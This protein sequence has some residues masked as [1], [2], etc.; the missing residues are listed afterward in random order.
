VDGSDARDSRNRITSLT[1]PLKGCAPASI[2]P[3]HAKHLKPLEPGGSR[4]S[5][6]LS[7]LTR[8]TRSLQTSRSGER[9]T[10][11]PTLFSADILALLLQ[12]K[13]VHRMLWRSTGRLMRF[14]CKSTRGGD[15]GTHGTYSNAQYCDTRLKIQTARG[16]RQGHVLQAVIARQADREWK[17]SSFLY[18]NG[19][20][21]PMKKGTI[22]SPWRYDKFRLYAPQ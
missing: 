5:G 11:I 13:F 20:P 16:R 8:R 15:L 2:V 22:V 19:A 9:K 17:C 21:R 14:P 6:L 12:R 3:H 10:D 7:P 1:L 4:Y 18:A